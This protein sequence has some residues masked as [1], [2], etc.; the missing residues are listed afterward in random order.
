MSRC[1]L[2]CALAR[3][4]RVGRLL[5]QVVRYHREDAF[6]A[7][8]RAFPDAPEQRIRGLV[9][10]MYEHLGITL[11][12]SLRLLTEPIEELKARIEW[13]GREILEEERKAGRGVCVLTAHTGNWELAC[14]A[15]PLFGL[16]LTA[17]VKPIRG[18]ALAEHVRAIRTRFG[19]QV[20]PSR[21]AYRDCLRA[22]RR[23]DLLGFVLDQNMTRDEG[24]FVDFFGRPACTTTG[25]AHM[26][27]RA[28]SRVVPV[29]MERLE[30]GRHVIHVHPAMDPP[31]DTKPE[32][33]R[34][35]TQVYTRCIENHIRAHPEQWIWIHRRWRT[36][37]L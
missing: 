2:P 12:E 11:V 7:L 18:R 23:N 36:V 14:A 30:G 10:G 15:T 4:R 8:R 34:A 16:P 17:V 6:D 21:N 35:A 24:V 1:S 27:A 28:G 19:L 13:R 32:T 22:L 31:P 33:L 29:F 9:R 25:L 26:A 3:G 37:S 5:E 20:L